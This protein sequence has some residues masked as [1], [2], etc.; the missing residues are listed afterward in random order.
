MDQTYFG[1]TQKAIAHLNLALG[2]QATGKEQ[3]WEIEFA[4]PS[5]LDSML[6]LLA[7]DAL[8]L[9]T[10]NALGALILHTVQEAYD[11]G[12]EVGDAVRLLRAFMK[13]NPDVRAQMIGYW[14]R[15]DPV[16]AALT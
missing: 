8:D 5:K 1:P 11:D 16:L 15:Y 12:I 2:L 13:A 9:D 4:D 3:D 6:K 10:K 7:R 14:E